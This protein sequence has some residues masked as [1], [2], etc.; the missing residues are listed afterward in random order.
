MGVSGIAT[1]GVKYFIIKA[2]VGA[3]KITTTVTSAIKDFRA[4]AGICIWVMRGGMRPMR[5]RAVR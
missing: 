1:A 2:M 3:N 4:G 5:V